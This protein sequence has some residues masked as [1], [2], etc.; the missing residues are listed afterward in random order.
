M[1]QHH[2]AMRALGLVLGAVVA[3]G[4]CA[5]SITSDGLHDD[6]IDRTV[7]PNG[8]AA[9][10]GDSVGLG[11]VVSGWVWSRLSQDGWGPVRS[12]SVVGMHAAP[13]SKTDVNTVAGWIGTFRREGLS[14]KVLVVIA[15]SNDVGYP[16][17]GVVANDVL[18]IEK[19][20]SAIGATPTV[21][22]T[23][24]HPNVGFMN[25]WNAALRDVATRHQ[26]LLV[27][28]WAGQLALH[29]A[30][31][32]KDRVHMTLGPV[33]GY[34]AMRQFVAACVKEAMTTP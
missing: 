16:A 3:I 18:R 23:I 12:F 8:P 28:D 2:R 14:P 33:G 27:C 25:A 11:L 17:G 29:P 24:S 5:M 30:Y 20:M 4:A 15:G 31:L 7:R 6:R 1:I 9:I 34:V 21:W 10:L 32:A 22:T 26:N 13:E 19:A